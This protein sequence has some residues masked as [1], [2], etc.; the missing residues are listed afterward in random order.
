MAWSATIRMATPA[1]KRLGGIRL[2]DLL[3][4][5]AKIRAHEVSD[6]QNCDFSAFFGTNRE[7]CDLVDV[8]TRS[9]TRNGFETR[10]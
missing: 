2:G 1:L 7:E 9:R 5:Y 4:V 3:E 10:G 8:H 6:H